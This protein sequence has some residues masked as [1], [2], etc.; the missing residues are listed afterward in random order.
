MSARIPAP[1]ADLTPTAG[2]FAP[3]PTRILPLSGKSEK[4][5]SEVA[6]RY[7]S[8]L[9]TNV[10]SSSEVDGEPFDAD[11]DT[12][13]D[14][15][16]TAGSGRSHFAHRAGL[17]FHDADSLWGRLKALAHTHGEPG[18]T[19]SPEP[20]TPPKTAFVYAGDELLQPGI[21]KALHDTEPVFRAVLNR[22]DAVFREAGGSAS[23]VDIILGR[24]GADRDLED[25]SCV[26]PAVY[27]LQ[28][29]LTS[30]WTSVGVQPGIVA[31]HGIGELAA[32]QAAGVFTLED[33]LRLA[34]ARGAL[35]AVPRARIAAAVPG[36]DPSGDSQD[37]LADLEAV[38]AGITISPPSRPILGQ[39]NG[40]VPEPDALLDP[41]YWREWA[42]SAPG[43]PRKIARALAKRDVQAVVEIGPRPTTGPITLRDWP[44][45]PD[46][47]EHDFA[48]SVAKA[49]EAGLPVS[50]AGMF[51]GESR[52]RISLP[53]YP[54]QR[55]RHWFGPIG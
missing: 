13:A 27:A 8:W 54:F 45:G 15:A 24:A 22:C 48:K 38:L 21:G 51:A 20:P 44:D 46:R 42:G 53:G 10:G 25:A 18:P 29:A 36:G 34:A 6:Q 41:A 16:F 31:G 5:L 14:M 1:L 9:E 40:D 52:R 30:L 11:A 23:L 33:G 3:R 47:D 17:V 4:A 35:M 43:S 12:L 2:E 28:C 55:E 37:R 49:Y 26:Q 39:A 19:R 32:A 50:F 7:L